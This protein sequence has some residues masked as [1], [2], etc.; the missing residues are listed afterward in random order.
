M[1][2]K[3]L[4]KRHLWLP[5][6]S[7]KPGKP[8][9][10]VDFCLETLLSILLLLPQFIYCRLSSPPCWVAKPSQLVLSSLVSPPDPRSHS[11]I[12]SSCSFQTHVLNI[13]IWVGPSLTY[14]IWWLPLRMKSKPIRMK[15]FLGSKPSGCVLSLP[16]KPHLSSFYLYS[17][18]HVSTFHTLF[19]LQALHLLFPLSRMPFIIFFTLILHAWITSP[20]GQVWWLYCGLP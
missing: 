9:R 5:F 1:E 4:K 15:S 11:S 16:P 10:P 20:P 6:F 14:K 17:L 13:P 2:T 12:H 19:Y 7:I 3:I 18:A 8:P